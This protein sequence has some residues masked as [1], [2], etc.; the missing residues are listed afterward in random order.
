LSLVRSATVFS[1]VFS[2]HTSSCFVCVWFPRRI[3]PPAGPPLSLFITRATGTLLTPTRALKREPS[4]RRHNKQTDDTTTQQYNHHTTTRHMTHASH[5]PNTQPR[6]P[7]S[8][9]S[10]PHTS[11]SSYEYSLQRQASQHPTSPRRTL[12]TEPRASPATSRSCGRI[13]RLPRS[14]MPRTRNE[15]HKPHKT[16]SPVRHSA[17]TSQ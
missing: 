2:T 13:V 7:S 3:R 16:I 1:H 12:R 17:R 4:H 10:L 6:R 9:L 11:N 8:T 5:T 14:P 15:P